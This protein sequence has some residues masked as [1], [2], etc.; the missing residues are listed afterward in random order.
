MA[1]RQEPKVIE[2]TATH[3]CGKAVG[4]RLSAAFDDGS[5]TIGRAENNRLLLLDPERRISRVQAEVVRR[6]TEY[7][8]ANCG[9]SRI[10]VNGAN[11]A[12]GDKVR[13]LDGDE[14]VIGDYRLRVAAAS[15]PAEQT[16]ATALPPMPPP[17]PARS[18]IIGPQ[19]LIPEDFDLGPAQLAR[20]C[21][22]ALMPAESEALWAT[23]AASDTMPQTSVSDEGGRADGPG[24]SV[25][26]VASA[27]GLATPLPYAECGVAGAGPPSH[28]D[29]ERALLGAL[30]PP[31]LLHGE[32]LTPATMHLIGEL[33]REAVQGTLELLET[34][35]MTKR[36]IRADVTMIGRRDNNPLKLSPDV[37]EALTHLLAPRDRGFLPPLSAMKDAYNDLRSHESGLMAGMQA[38]LADVL[39]R[40]NPKMLEKQLKQSPMLE[41]LLPMH[42]KARMWDLFGGVYK[43]ISEDARED[44]RSV[45]GKAFVRAYEER[46]E[47]L[48]DKELPAEGGG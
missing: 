40:F 37:G 32:G 6:G 4:Q 38:A 1:A 15:E 5:G 23:V 46:V 48:R 31:D 35:A 16:L 19:S 42:R 17:E 36:E 41:N 30:G 34:R 39:R 25:P 13:L 44:F 45:F 8:L 27:H 14:I 10:Q 12:P 28:S 2:I 7:F 3:F 11:L 21:A 43:E 29:L 22:Q 47:S 26:R 33:L 18:K 9:S 20:A 24:H